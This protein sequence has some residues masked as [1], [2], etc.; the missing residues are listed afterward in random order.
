MILPQVHPASVLIFQEDAN[1]YKKY[2]REML[3]AL[4]VGATKGI[5]HGMR[6]HD[7]SNH[8]KQFFS[9]LGLFQSFVQKKHKE[10][11]YQ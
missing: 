9:P 4:A 7:G 8:H 5:S 3:H 10:H 11:Q 6:G 2:L 1:E